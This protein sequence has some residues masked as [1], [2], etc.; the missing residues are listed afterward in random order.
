VFTLTKSTQGTKIDPE[1]IKF[2]TNIFQ[3]VRT[4]GFMHDYD[5]DFKIVGM[6]LKKTKEYDMIQLMNLMEYFKQHGL[7]EVK[8]MQGW[9]IWAFKNPQT[10]MQPF[11]TIDL[12]KNRGAV[13]EQREASKATGREYYD[14]LFESA[15]SA[16]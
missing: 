6:A 5:G 10:A 15:N 11:N 9:L 7:K 16:H 14:Q 13:N 3:E 4:E 8:S 12:Q 2:L 1:H